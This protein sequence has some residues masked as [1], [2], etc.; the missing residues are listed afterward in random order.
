MDSRYFQSTASH[1]FRNRSSGT[2]FDRSSRSYGDGWTCGSC[3]FYNF[4]SRSSCL[5]C[6]PNEG[7]RLSGLNSAS[8]SEKW[9]CHQCQFENFASRTTCYKCGPNGGK[10]WNSKNTTREAS[11]W[12][13]PKCHFSNYASRTTCFKCGPSGG[14]TLTSGASSRKWSSRGGI[15]KYP[16][17]DGSGSWCDEEE[18]RPPRH[19]YPQNLYGD[20]QTNYKKYSPSASGESNIYSSKMSFLD[21]LDESNGS[22]RCQKAEE[23]GLI[24][25]D[26]LK[27]NE[28]KFEA[29]RWA[30]LPEIKK[31]FY[32]EDPDVKAMSNKQVQKFRE[33][34]F[35]IS[36]SLCNPESEI[37]IPNPVHTFNQAFHNYPEILKEI[38][39]QGFEHPTPIQCQSWPILMKG[40]DMIGIAQTGTGKTLA[41]ILPALIHIVHQ[42]VPRWERL[43]PTCLVLAPTRELAQQIEKEVT[44][45]QYQNIRCVVVYGQGDKRQQIRQINAKAEIVVATPGRLN[46]F[47]E[48][49]IINLS[50]VSYLVL[51]E[52]D[53]MLDM[54]FEPQ[55]RK[56]ILDI[57]PDRQSVLTSATWPEG[58]RSLAAKLLKNPI[59]V[60][61][62]SLDLQ[63]AST[64]S[65]QVIICKEEE[66]RD[67]LLD[68]INRLGEEDKAIVFVGRKSMV[69]YLSVEMMEEGKC[70]QSMH[71]DREQEEREKALSDLKSGRVRV[72]L[73]TD[74]A[75]RG[76]D[77]IDI[78]Y[79][80]NF[81]CPRDMEEYVHRIGR[82]GRA[83]RQGHACTFITW[84]DWKNA[85]RL[86]EILE[87]SGEVVDRELY[88][89][90]ERWEKTKEER[91]LQDRCGRYSHTA[92]REGGHRW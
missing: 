59:H 5:K 13:C 42:P 72:L 84:K 77:V 49:E 1:D 37:D 12:T 56:I 28:E 27:E 36:V 70:V 9:R 92:Q 54:G 83:G 10:R 81:D 91:G 61:V 6:G 4:G 76:I 80:L 63:A 17:T 73:A 88:R 21:S 48:K 8:E 89:M 23:E 31:N 57:R 85:G 15:S 90:K 46:E 45:Y 29:E 7:K 16:T 3:Q 40:H 55:I 20:Q 65:Q 35:N 25:W 69:D 11:D 26:F 53:R 79:I 38:E 64:V 44:K 22:Q 47:S 86:I 19:S 2:D 66:K 52:A 62:G 67:K 82:T 71:G 50:G 41:F 58:V 14:T 51:D 18:S 68:F 39:K 60:V 30:H 74:V 32:V 75:A 34:N 33:E 43:G 87:K 24:D 78:T